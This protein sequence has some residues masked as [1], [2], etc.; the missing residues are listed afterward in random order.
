QVVVA[1]LNI[2]MQFA[3]VIAQLLPRVRKSLQRGARAQLDIRKLPRQFDRLLPK[4][5][6][7]GPALVLRF[8]ES[9]LLLP[10]GRTLVRKRLARAGDVATKFLELVVLF[11]MMR[12]TAFQLELPRFHG[13]DLGRL[14]LPPRLPLGV[15]LLNLTHRLRLAALDSRYLRL[16]FLQFLVQ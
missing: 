14:L 4:A 6:Q 9:F 2:G 1:L 12:L 3:Q 15:C 8:E 5:I 16:V 11:P 10:G 13:L 7:L